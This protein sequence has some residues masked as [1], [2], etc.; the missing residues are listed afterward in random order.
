MKRNEA[1]ELQDVWGLTE[2]EAQEVLD[3][4]RGNA[5]GK[6][7]ISALWRNIS[8]CAHEEAFELDYC[9]ENSERYFNFDLFADDLLESASYYELESG[10]VVYFNY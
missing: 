5:K 1:K 3:N 8:D 2:E 10:K 7:V 6:D 9:N 4:Y